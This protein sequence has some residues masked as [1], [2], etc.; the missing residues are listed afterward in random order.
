VYHCCTRLCD[1]AVWRG[2][3]GGLERVEGLATAVVPTFEVLCRRECDQMAECLDR[4]VSCTR[5]FY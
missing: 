5:G 4:A 2:D 3:E 1:Q